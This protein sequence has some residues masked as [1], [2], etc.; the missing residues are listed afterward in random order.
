MTLAALGVDAGG[1]K[2]AGVLATADGE[3][4][5]TS[6]GGG[7]NYH[8][9]G[10]TAAGEVYASVVEP[11][12]AA[13]QER[14]LT[15]TAAAFGLSGLDRPVDG[16][17]L[18]GLVAQL[19]PSGVRSVCVNDTSLIL[20]AGTRDGVGVAVVSGTGSNCVGRGA[21]GAE[22]R[23]GGF[24]HTFGD[25]GSADDIGREGA[26]AAFR[27]EDGRA[28]PTGL[29][30]LLM[31]RF[32]LTDLHD[33]IDRFLPDAPEGPLSPGALAPLVFEAA[34]AGD[35]VC[36]AILTA[37]GAELGH[38]AVVVGR[39][40]FASGAALPLVLGGAV[41]Q[42]GRGERMRDAFIARV[43]EDFPEASI[44]TLTGPPVL[45]AALFA[46]DQLQDDAVRSDAVR[47][48]LLQG[49]EGAA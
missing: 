38:A 39:Q 33:L 37:A 46:L 19:L 49:L 7:G 11:L 9:I 43:R 6:L 22:A 16:D 29:R 28:E 23:I 20:R 10:L 18:R 1:T 41:W 27:A 42:R 25:D 48:R 47:A 44:S 3:V 26:R 4:V 36:R 13:A 35:A 32:E 15:V 40:L 14:G 5:A 21:D 24:G 2:T 34:E 45:G 12:L 8:A 17:R 31:A 30:D